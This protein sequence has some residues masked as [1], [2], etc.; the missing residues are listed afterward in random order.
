MKELELIIPSSNGG[1]CRL[2]SCDIKEW[3]DLSKGERTRLRRCWPKR[4]SRSPSGTTWVDISFL[5]WDSAALGYRIR[6]E[7]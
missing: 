1:P 4:S 6:T 3:W 5:P 7:P 2:T